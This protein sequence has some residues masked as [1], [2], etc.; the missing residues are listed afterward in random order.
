MIDNF[1]LLYYANKDLTYVNGLKRSLY[2]K[3]QFHKLYSRIQKPFLNLCLKRIFDLYPNSK[4]HIL[5]N[6]KIAIRSSLRNVYQHIDSDLPRNHLAKLKL[7]N[8]IDE[9]CLYMDTD[10]VLHRRF[11]ESE[12]HCPG[13]FKM[14]QSYRMEKLAAY[15]DLSDFLAYNAGMIYIK[16]PSSQLVSD[17]EDIQKNV[18]CDLP[19][20]DKHDLPQNVDEFA[21]SYWCMKN[22]IVMN[23][24]PSVSF[25][26]AHIKSL[27]QLVNYQSVHYM[28]LKYKLMLVDEFHKIYPIFFR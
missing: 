12:L 21:V 5:T 2:P 15:L 8:T 9:P 20:L 16:E 7:Y 1:L 19:K 4:V 26:R 10:I 17:F 13:Q 3:E 27:E 24:S 25:P 14:F 22:N 6:K 23:P 11:L 18:F 28:H